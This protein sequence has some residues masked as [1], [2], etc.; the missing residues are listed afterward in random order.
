MATLGKITR[1]GCYKGDEWQSEYKYCHNCST[2]SGGDEI[3]WTFEVLGDD[4]QL[5]GHVEA[6]LACNKSC[7]SEDQQKAKL[8]QIARGL[9]PG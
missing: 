2:K 4:G 1:Q 3:R 7:G 6:T 9:L 5:I 8:L